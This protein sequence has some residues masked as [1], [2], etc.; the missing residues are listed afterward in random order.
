MIIIFGHQDMAKGTFIRLQ[1]RKSS[2][3]RFER[4][5]R[6]STYPFELS[7]S[8][9]KF[10]CTEV[11]R[12]DERTDEHWL[13]RFIFA[14]SSYMSIPICNISHTPPYDQSMPFCSILD[15]GVNS[16]KIFADYFQMFFF[17]ERTIK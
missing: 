1:L 8:V 4:Q 12:T 2:C 17:F 11:S 14:S 7:L 9:P 13:N 5:D 10:Y 16:G 6:F 15:I 3:D